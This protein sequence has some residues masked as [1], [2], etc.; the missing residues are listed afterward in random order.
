MLTNSF[1]VVQYVLK[2]PLVWEE[3][4]KQN[5]VWNGTHTSRN[6][7]VRHVIVNRA[8]FTQQLLI[9]AGFYGQCIKR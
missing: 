2:K 1:P 3:F 7:C 6:L 5:E 8:L 4:G 9:F